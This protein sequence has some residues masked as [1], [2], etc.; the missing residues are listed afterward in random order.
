MDSDVLLDFLLTSMLVLDPK[1]RLP[2]RECWKQALQLPPLSESRCATPTQAAFTNDRT[3]RSATEVAT[4]IRMQALQET[5][6]ALS[7]VTV[8]HYLIGYGTGDQELEDQ[9]SLVNEVSKY[10]VISCK[11]EPTRAGTRS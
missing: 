4:F 9:Q 6:T 1:G 7:Q 10:L 2:A 5:N 8:D 3:T 11:L